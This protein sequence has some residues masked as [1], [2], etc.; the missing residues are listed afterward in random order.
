MDPAPNLALVGPTGAGKTSIGRRLGER[1]GLDFVDMDREIEAHAGTS[2]ATIFAAEGEPGFRARESAMLREL[3][4]GEGRLVATGAGAVLDAG[5]R[6]LLRERAFIVHLHIDASG[7][8]QRLARD[9]TRPLLQREDREDVLRAMAAQRDPLYTEVADLR[10]DTTGLAAD[11]AA[12]AL[13]ALLQSRWHRPQ[14]STTT[15]AS[16]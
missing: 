12:E 7:Q 4:A 14:R 9:R 1:L 13:A 2:V 15:Q 6:R 3:L 8:L 10:F 11:A 5:N 16:A